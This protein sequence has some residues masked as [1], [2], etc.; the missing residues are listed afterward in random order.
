MRIGNLVG[1]GT[2]IALGGM[3]LIQLA[4]T[5]AV[6]NTET[7]GASKDFAESSER[8]LREYEALI[9]RNSQTFDADGMPVESANQRANRLIRESQAIPTVGERVKEV[10]AKTAELEAVE[11]RMKELCSTGQVSSGCETLD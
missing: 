7:P 10:E 9:E 4:Q 8:G 11:A 2:A 5:S 3:L 1:I 6:M